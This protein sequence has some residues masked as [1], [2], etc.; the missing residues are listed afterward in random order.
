MHR[1][2]FGTLVTLLCLVAPD[3]GATPDFPGVVQ[4]YVGA[5][6]PPMC[7]ICH[8]N[9]SGGIGTVTTTFGMY[10]R[11]RGLVAFDESSLQ[12][13]LAADR[14]EMHVSNDQGIDDIDALAR[15]LDPNNP[16]TADGG[17]GAQPTPPAYGC[18]GSVAGGARGREWNGLAPMLAIAVLLVSRCLR[19][20][21]SAGS[22]TIRME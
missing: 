2:F 7:T 13:A 15:G 20:S 1:C 6:Q 8:N 17:E 14:A 22:E 21:R 18:V 11:S 5:A 10:M 19:R 4:S 12:N 3:A 9:R 16:T